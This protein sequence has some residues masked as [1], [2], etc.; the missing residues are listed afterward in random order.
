[1]LNR[2]FVIIGA[3]AAGIAVINRVRR[4]APAAKITCISQEK[5]LPYNKCLLADFLAGTKQHDQVLLPISDHAGTGFLFNTSVVAINSTEK[6]VHCSDGSI[7]GYDALFLGLGSSPVMPNF[8]TEYSLQGLY[9]FHTL[10][11]TF[12]LLDAIKMRS[13][14]RAVVVGGGLSGLECAD[15]LIR[16]DITTVLIERQAGL[17]PNFLNDHASNF[18]QS[19]IEALGGTVL[20]NQSVCAIESEQNKVIGVRLES[21]QL[22]DADAVIIAT[23]VRPNTKLA[24]EAGILIGRQGITENSY[25]QTSTPD[26]YAGGD[27]IEIVDTLKNQLIA[28]CTWPDAM[29]QGLHAAQAMVGQ[30]KEYKGAAI[31]VSSSFFGLD[32]ARA[33]LMEQCHDDDRFVLREGIDYCNQYLVN[34]G[35]LK[36]FCVLGKR[37]NLSQLKRVILTGE[38]FLT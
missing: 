15:V 35:R 26:V 29:L 38:P 24:Q 33:G 37:H 28:S 30:P 9:A 2:H 22:F 4:L 3:S 16:S 14:K 31:I 18:L 34:A 23:G 20:T 19:Q 17:L 13:I 11:D 25:L 27:A 32:F 6:T 8:V 1:M 7:V 21:G 5:E 36:G 10:A 12:Q